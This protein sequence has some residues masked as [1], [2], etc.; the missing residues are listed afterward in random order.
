MNAS[1]KSL[2][3]SSVAHS[4]ASVRTGATSTLLAAPTGSITVGEKAFTPDGQNVM[5]L[6]DVGEGDLGTLRLRPISGGP[7]RTLGRSVA[8]AEIDAAS[9]ILLLDDDYSGPLFYAAG[10][11][12]AIH[13]V[14]P[15][16][17]PPAVEVA[18]RTDLGKL[19]AGSKC[20]FIRGEGTADDGLYVVD[21]PR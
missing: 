2:Q 15:P 11:K 13:A 3:T 4:P 5:W 19:L 6:E 1:R 10:A 7:A 17:Q 20:Y 16:Y 14:A 9:G 8:N 21:L 18:A 12:M